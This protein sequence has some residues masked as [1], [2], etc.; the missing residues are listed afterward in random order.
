M[1]QK[2]VHKV[3]F[4]LKSHFFLYLSANAYVHAQQLMHNKMKKKIIIFLYSLFRS[5]LRFAKDTN[6]ILSHLEYRK[7]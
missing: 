2:R 3:E 1:M 5:S 7:D 4:K 6:L